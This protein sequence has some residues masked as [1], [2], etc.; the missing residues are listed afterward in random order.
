MRKTYI[1]KVGELSD[2]SKFQ[3]IAVK[4]DNLFKFITSQENALMKFIKSLLTLT[5]CPKKHEDLK[6]VGTTPEIK[7]GYLKS[8]K[9]VPMAVGLS[10]QF[11]L[12]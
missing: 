2:Q 11:Y 9:N 5:A 8:I 3:K 1:K 10:D 4:N 12:L 7:Y 6:P